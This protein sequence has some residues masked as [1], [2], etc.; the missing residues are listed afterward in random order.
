MQNYDILPADTLPSVGKYRHL[1]LQLLP[2]QSVTLL[3][4]AKLL[5]NLNL[6]K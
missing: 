2:T 4:Y 3:L 1:L 5:S 6:A